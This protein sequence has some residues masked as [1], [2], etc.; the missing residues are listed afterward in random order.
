[1]LVQL[2]V[3]AKHPIRWREARLAV[4]LI[5]FMYAFLYVITVR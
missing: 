5:Y 2:D 1:L 3:L 4:G